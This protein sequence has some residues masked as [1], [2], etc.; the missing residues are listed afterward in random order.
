MSIDSVSSGSTAAARIDAVIYT[1]VSTPARILQGRGAMLQKYN[2]CRRSSQQLNC[3]LR[4]V[5]M[6]HHRSGPNLS[7]GYPEQGPPLDIM[8]LRPWS[9]PFSGLPTAATLLGT[10][11]VNPTGV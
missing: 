1:I 3:K 11:I 2:P 9:G 8:E 6:H 4:C 7:G 5:K 10:G